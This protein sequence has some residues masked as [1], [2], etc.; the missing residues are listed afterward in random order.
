MY[1]CIYV[2]NL[3]VCVFMTWGERDCLCMSCVRTC[4][5]I[6]MY[7]CMHVCMLCSRICESYR[8]DDHEVVCMYV[9]MYV[10]EKVFVYTSDDHEFVCVVCMG[11]TQTR[12]HA[13]TH[14]RTHTH[15]STY[16]VSYITPPASSRLVCTCADP[17]GT[18][19]SPFV[20]HVLRGGPVCF[21]ARS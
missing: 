2:C 20:S 4:K 5:Y 10:C 13:D 15:I 12:R 16:L 8:G 19:P 21:R 3:C 9:C 14:T 6:R 11:Y 7:V 18:C 17:G 1:V